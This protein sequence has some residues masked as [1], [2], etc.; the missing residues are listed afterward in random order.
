M[1][2]RIDELVGDAFARTE[3]ATMRLTRALRREERLALIAPQQPVEAPG[4]TA[5]A[6]PATRRCPR[7]P[8][9]VVALVSSGR[10]V[11]LVEMNDPPGYLRMARTGRVHRGKSA[12]RV[13]R[14]DGPTHLMARFRCGTWRP[15]GRASC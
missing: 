6:E 9:P 4:A 1:T 11:T 13:T 15:I 14:R 3:A 8:A 5:A 12:N 7:A 10:H 2:A